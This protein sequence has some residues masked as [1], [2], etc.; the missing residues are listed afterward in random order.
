MREEA[1]FNRKS[2][3]ADFWSRVPL[4]AV[5]KAFKIYKPDFLMFGYKVT[6]YFDELG[7][8]Q[9]GVYMATHFEGIEL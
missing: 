8:T 4:G 2:F 9:T 6:D 3:E 7:M 5:Y 1:E